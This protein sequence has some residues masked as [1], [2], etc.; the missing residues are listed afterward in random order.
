MKKWG[1]ISGNKKTKE[2]CV[3][4]ICKTLRNKTAE[5]NNDRAPIPFVIPAFS[6]CIILYFNTP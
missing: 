6:V 4:Y 5:R 2:R 1:K 3:K